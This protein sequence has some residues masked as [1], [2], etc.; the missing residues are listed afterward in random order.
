[1]AQFI[2][3]SGS[4]R[5]EDLLSRA[6]Y[7]FKVKPAEVEEW[8]PGKYPFRELCMANAALKA[9]EVSAQYPEAVVLGADTLVGLGGRI[10]GK[11]NDIEDAIS[12]LERLSGRVHEVC[13]GVCICC[14]TAEQVFFEVAWVRF[15]DFGKDLIND[16]IKRVNVMDKAGAY[17]IQEQGE[18]LVDKVEGP[19]D[20]VV[21]LPMAQVAGE[22]EQFGILPN[23][24]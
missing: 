11:P 8:P 1:M 7:D 23:R 17:A 16:Y 13:T 6:G 9:R 21:G 10:M 18:M 12:M 20:N 22:L 4:P 24:T 14:G 5:R 3:A 19:F 2:L 15:R